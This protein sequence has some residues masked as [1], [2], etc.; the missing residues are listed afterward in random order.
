MGKGKDGHHV[1][2]NHGVDYIRE[3]QDGAYYS[4]AGAAAARNPTKGSMPMEKEPEPGGKRF[5]T[6]RQEGDFAMKKLGQV[7]RGARGSKGRLGDEDRLD[8][9]RN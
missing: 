8:N 5:P 2:V 4:A 1:Q 3:A 6:G 9:S 7:K